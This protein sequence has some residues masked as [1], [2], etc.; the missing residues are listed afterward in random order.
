MYVIY[1]D[2]QPQPIQRLLDRG[3]KI[4][5]K[6]LCL[7]ITAQSITRIRSDHIPSAVDTGSDL[8]GKASYFRF[9]PAWTN[10]PG[11]LS[12]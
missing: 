4:L 6:I 12:F 2:K 1:M 9:E 7:H 5:G 11:F 3:C 8:I 10:Q